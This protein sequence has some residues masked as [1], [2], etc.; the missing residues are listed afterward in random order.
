MKGIFLVQ[1]HAKTTIWQWAAG[2]MVSPGFRF[3][4]WRYYGPPGSHAKKPRRYRLRFKT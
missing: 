3:G 4:F 2:L 1:Q